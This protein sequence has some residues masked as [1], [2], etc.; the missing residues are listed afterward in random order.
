M[1]LNRLWRKKRL[2]R[3]GITEI[4]IWR[5][6]ALFNNF[7]RILFLNNA[8][9]EEMT[10]LERTLGG[11][12]IFDNSFLEASVRT[13]ASRV[14][15]VTYN[16][17]ALTGNS[18]IPLY[19][20]YQRIRTILDDILS[21]NTRAL[22]AVPVLPLYQVS[23]ELEQLVG[24]DL[25]CLAELQ[26]HPGIQA[27]RGFVVTSEGSRTL[28]RQMISPGAAGKDFTADD[29]RAGMAEQFRQLLDNRRARRFSVVVTG[30]DEQVDLVTEIAR[31]FLIPDREKN[32]IE[33]VADPPPFEKLPFR[34]LDR[35]DPDMDERDRWIDQYVHSLEQIVH[36]L[37][38]SDPEEEVVDVAERIVIFVRC[39][40]VPAITGSVETRRGGRSITDSLT[41]IARTPE[42]V[43]LPD[44]YRLRRTYPFDILQSILPPRPAGY[45]FADGRLATS[46]TVTQSGHG[47]ERG[48]ALLS[49]KILKSLAETSMTLERVLGMPVTI[50]WDI[51]ED[52]SCY[53]TRLYQMQA[54]LDQVAASELAEVEASAAILCQGGQMVQSGVGAGRVVHV[55]DEMSPAEFPAG[56]VAV[57]RFASPQLTPV[58]Q[59]AAAVITEYGTATGHLAT[60]ARELRLPALFGVAKA[61]SLLPS[62]IEVTVHA[63]E[64]KVYAGVLDILLRKGTGELSF[65]PFDQEYRT[66]RRLLRFIM[67]L[68]LI[69]PEA[70]NFSPEG[71]RTFHDIIHFC[72][73]KAVDELAHF[74]ERRPGLGAIRTSRMQ[75]GVPMDIRVLDIGGGLA[76][77]CQAN[78]L[79]A[80]IRSDPFAA[81]LEGLL[82]PGAWAD[83]QPSLGF[84]DIVSSM[85]RSMGMLTGPVDA[86]G[87]NLAIVG[88]EYVNISLRLGYHFSVVDAHLGSDDSRNYVYFRFAGGL[89]DPERRGRRAR[90]IRDVLKAMDF[91]VSVKGDLVIGRIKSDQPR[92]LR[93]ALSALGALT[94]F[95]R[96][97]DTSLYSDEDADILFRLF[98]EMFLVQFQHVVSDIYGE[99]ESQAEF[100]SAATAG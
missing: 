59:R 17:N 67:P 2:R 20:S 65:S 50:E 98:A 58:L 74:Q 12:F 93:A 95:S 51:L 36:F 100:S 78:P 73:E 48:S 56:A 81:F 31:F 68:S 82:Q 34:V 30:I 89:A 46:H 41:I 57:A 63:G 45:R 9:L 44:T 61:C 15:H 84:R 6:Q 18:Y 80:D 33:I 4:N 86:L 55:S 90:F 85:P 83:N 35:Q 70:A 43:D 38:S 39:S 11:E 29:V 97:R 66:L 96:Q 69:D 91:K 8:V 62:G 53:I 28:F 47:C 64:S 32:R 37:L 92:I 25:V 13:L 54:A 79:P 16:L 72:H 49:G 88:N 5:L 40:P 22:A 10:H 14:H 71:C 76:A 42:L 1:W 75:L 21:G 52:G 99:W 77:D 3:T 94:A 19:D 26:H 87:D 24:V 27:A 23:W 7:R 60:V